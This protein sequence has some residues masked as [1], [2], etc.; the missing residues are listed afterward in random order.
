MIVQEKRERTVD[1][2]AGGLWAVCLITAIMASI[3]ILIAA[4]GLGLGMRIRSVID[5]GR[6]IIYM[7][8]ISKHEAVVE[9]LL[10]KI[11]G[12]I[13]PGSQ[14]GIMDLEQLRATP[15]KDRS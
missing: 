2:I 13:Q 8:A 15:K 12:T 10:S 6:V 11:D 1:L 9:Y 14:D 4:G 3:P 5:R 7:D